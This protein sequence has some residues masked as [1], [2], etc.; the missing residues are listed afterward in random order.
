MNLVEN[1]STLINN[2]HHPRI[3]KRKRQGKSTNKNMIPFFSA[4]GKFFR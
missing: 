2:T 4:L 3:E 1:M